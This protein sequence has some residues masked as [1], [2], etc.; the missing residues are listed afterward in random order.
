[1]NILTVTNYFPPFHGGGYGLQMGWFCDRLA[2]RGHAMTVLTS[3]SD[4]RPSTSERSAFPVQRSLS[5]LDQRN[6]STR[7]LNA[8]TI[9][10]RNSVK[11]AIRDLCPDIIF[12]GGFDGLGFNTYLAAIES[13]TPSYTWLGDTWLG[14][15]WRDLPRYDAWVGLASGAGNGGLR[16]AVKRAIGFYG[17]LRGLSAG[18]PPRS[19]GSVGTLSQFVLDDLR[20]AQ[21]PVSED[22]RVI[23]GNLHPAF[24]RADGEPI[25][26]SGI[27]T[28]E[29]RAL[30][31]GRMELLKGPD[32]AI[33]GVAAAVSNGAN[34]RLTF[35]GIRIDELRPQLMEMA[36]S[37]GV[38]DRITFAGTPELNELISLYRNHDVFLFPSRI[39]EGLGMVNAEALACGLPIIGTA[40]SGSAEVILHEKSGYRIDKEDFEGMGQYLARLHSD[41]NLLQQLSDN[42]PEY[43]RRFAPDKVIDALESELYKAAGRTSPKADRPR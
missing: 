42:A 11:K 39:V 5:T 6:I 41:R 29:L 7:E 24:F 18:H 16:R 30:F 17:R 38:S 23:G 28:P 31:V 10:N 32:T 33:R 26:H 20:S 8:R 4:S 34:I 36:T 9:R 12:C 2:E 19:F 14:Q 37:L 1:M 3:G 27:R 25:G 22:A 21:A 40:H 35:A 13:D 43:A 15:A